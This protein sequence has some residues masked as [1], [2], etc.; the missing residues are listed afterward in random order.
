MKENFYI[1][2][3]GWLVRKHNTIYFICKKAK[4][5]NLGFMKEVDEERQ[6]IELEKIEESPE[7]DKRIIP[8]ERILSIYILGRVSLTSGVLSFLSK[9]EIPV[10]FFGYYGQYEGSYYPREKYLSGYLHIRQA[11]H[12]L[13]KEKRMELARQFVAGS[14]QNILRNLEN[15]LNEGVDLYLEIESIRKLIPQIKEEKEMGK[16]MATEGFIRNLYYSTFDKIM[17]GRFVFDSRSRRPPQ[18]PLNAMIS[19]GNSL[20][21]STII[22]QIYHTQL[23]PTISYLHEPTERRF[24]LALDISEIFKPFLV[25]RIIFKLVN[26]RM[27]GEEHFRYELNSCLLNDSGRRLFIKEWN[28]RLNTTIKH[29]ELRRKVSYQRL[30]YLECL[31][32]IKHLTGVKKYRPFVIWW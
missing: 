32:L 5:E 24:S 31:K 28:D 13:D 25:D 3:N 21:Y 14:A 30:I 7:Y 9:H 19:F 22:T 6:E 15:Y 16:L 11:E 29:R 20:L 1:L 4:D 18:N 12:Y 2:K 27:M 8:V 26:K 23:D 10:H 17:G